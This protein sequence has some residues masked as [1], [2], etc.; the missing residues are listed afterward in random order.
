[1]TELTSGTVTRVRS[2]SESAMAQA[3]AI[4]RRAFTKIPIHGFTRNA[5]ALASTSEKSVMPLSETAISAL[6]GA[7]NEANRT[8]IRAWMKEGRVH[9]NT[10]SV[11][12]PNLASSA[13]GST[14]EQVLLRRLQWNEPVLEHLKD[15]CELEAPIVTV[16]W[17]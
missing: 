6:F 11:S 17:S 12:T 8:L 14:M 9:M 5:I 2:S 16:R 13:R 15:V 3:E 4:L 7:G 1:M 10:P